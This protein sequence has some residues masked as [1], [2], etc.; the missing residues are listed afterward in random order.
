MEFNLATLLS[1]LSII[2]VVLNF[3]FGRKD[4]T[5]KDIKDETKQFAKHE[6]IEWRLDRIDKQLERII[7]KLDTYDK[8]IDEKIDTAL[9]HHLREYHKKE[10][11]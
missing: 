4:K 2:F 9:M 8:E 5:T 6:L 10:N 1:I 11:V 3:V 7:E